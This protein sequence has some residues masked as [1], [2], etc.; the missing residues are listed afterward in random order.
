MLVLLLAMAMVLI[1]L[2]I[3]SALI[4]HTRLRQ[5]INPN[6]YIFS[7][8]PKDLAQFGGGVSGRWEVGVGGVNGAC[9]GRVWGACG[10]CV[11]RA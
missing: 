4:S 10:E 9:V 7:T 11:G 5:T 6:K 8:L 1:V 2:T 3:K